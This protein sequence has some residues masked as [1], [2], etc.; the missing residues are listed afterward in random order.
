MVELGLAGKA[1]NSM[2]EDELDK[3]LV[4]MRVVLARSELEDD[5]G[6]AVE[7]S[8]GVRI[9]EFWATGNG[10]EAGLVK[11]E[12]VLF[13]TLLVGQEA[14]SSEVEAGT[15]PLKVANVRNK[16]CFIVNARL[17]PVDIRWMRQ[18]AWFERGMVQEMASERDLEAHFD[19]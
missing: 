12:T 13:V 11:I 16:R 1:V 2:E 8:R 15:A 3:L 4:V 6:E 10:I 5:N 7:V 14:S 9:V 18:R 19:D 17:C